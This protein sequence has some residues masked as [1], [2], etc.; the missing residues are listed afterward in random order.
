MCN[1]TTMQSMAMTFNEIEL[2]QSTFEKVRR[3]SQVAAEAY[4]RA[5]AE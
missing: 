1:N 2:A 5:A 4:G 3:I